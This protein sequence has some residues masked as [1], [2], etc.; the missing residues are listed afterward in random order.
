MPHNI[1]RI[2]II[3]NPLG[4]TDVLLFITPGLWITIHLSP[5]Y[6]L[7]F[8]IFDIIS[9]YFLSILTTQPYFLDSS[10][11][12]ITYTYWSFWH[13]QC[14]WNMLS[15]KVLV[16]SAYTNATINQL[17]KKFFL[18]LEG[19]CMRESNMFLVSTHYVGYRPN[20]KKHIY[21]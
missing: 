10:F 4:V 9:Y 16:P 2:L 6:F 21:L 5:L 12:N 11:T 3:H 7:I 20:A 1:F 17:T 8:D 14:S 13:F 18:I 15:T 19:L